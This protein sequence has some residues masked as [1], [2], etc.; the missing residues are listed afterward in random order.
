VLAFQSIDLDFSTFS[1]FASIQLVAFAVI[2]GIGYIAGSLVAAGFVAGTLVATLGNALFPGQGSYL[3][4]IGGACLIITVLLN[5]DGL[6]HT[7]SKQLNN[8]GSKI[9]ARFR[10]PKGERDRVFADDSAV[11]SE[12]VGEA[13]LTVT[14]LSVRFGGVSAVR[15]VE[16]SI[17]NGRMLGLIGPNGAG[18]TTVI[19]AITGFVR[20]DKTSVISLNG[21]DISRWG[22]ER[23]AR[24]GVA[25]S[26]QSLELFED[27]TVLENIRTACDRRDLTS[28]FVDLVH[29]VQSELPA[30]AIAALQHFHL[31]DKLSTIVEELP[32]AQRR[33]VAIA[34]A[35]ASRPS[36]LLL[37][38]PAAGLG[39]AESKDLARLV[40]LLV[41]EWGLGVIVVEHDMQFV[42]SVCDEVVVLEFGAVIAA[43]EPEAVQQ[44]PAVLAAYL[45][46]EH[47]GVAL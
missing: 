4:L 19:D 40:R 1:T 46:E 33:M 6:M 13:I 11:P 43:G 10:T 5:E 9:M 12:R 25:R 14:Q 39:F 7:H 38:E 31:E 17:T 16:L 41:D 42:M 30:T 26:F 2:G 47:Q 36:I 15:D 37:D 44:E 28:Y 24:A 34:R 18:K 22:V 27:M 3:Q 23:R 29:P 21:V 35:L 32:Y 8:L 45:G 20:P